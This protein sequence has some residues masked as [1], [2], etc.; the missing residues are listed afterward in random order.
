MISDSDGKN[1]PWYGSTQEVKLIEGPKEEFQNF[2][3]TMN[4]NFHPHVTWDIP[5][6][7]ERIPRL[8]N[9][10]RDQFFYTWLVAMDVLKGNFIV[11]K[12]VQWQMKLEIHVD[13]NK[14]LGNRAKLISNPEQEQPHILKKNIKIPKCAL[15]PINANSAQVLIWRPYKSK[16]EMVIKPKYFRPTDADKVTWKVF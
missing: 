2:T 15:Y 11:L 3:V 13:P 16:P 6:S 10:K 12:T 1:Y 9:V 14:S 4:D 7:M 5:T 8:T